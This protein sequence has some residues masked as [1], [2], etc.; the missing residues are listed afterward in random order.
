LVTGKLKTGDQCDCFATLGCL[1]L[2]VLL[3]SSIENLFMSESSE[4]PEL[5]ESSTAPIVTAG[6]KGGKKGGGKSVVEKMQICLKKSHHDAASVPRFEIGLDEAGRGPLFGRVFVGG[7]VLPFPSSGSGSSGAVDDFHY[8]W[9]KDSKKFYSH[10]KRMEVAAYIREHA[11]AY[12][13][14]FVEA[15]EIDEINILQAVF[16]G[17]HECVRE[18]VRQL[19]EKGY[20]QQNLWK[21]GQEGIFL[22]VDGNRFD[23]IMEWNAET[24]RYDIPD[25]VTVEGGDNTYCSIAAASILA[26]TAHDEYIFQMCRDYPELERRYELLKGMGY[27]TKAHIEGIRKY[28][29]SQWHRKSF[30][31]N[32]RNAVVNLVRPNGQ[33]G[34]EKDE[35]EL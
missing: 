33:A 32:C 17:M 16:K 15:A 12:H 31:E 6:K 23:P 13:V 1:G 4:T 30:G 29:V 35:K 7:A 25:F 2:T 19:R 5:P 21:E 34:D 18:I 10:T 24:E 3:P 27:A 22:L 20:T 9:M 14:A 28:G 26:K 8:E 11:L